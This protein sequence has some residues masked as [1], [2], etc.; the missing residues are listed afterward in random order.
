MS[1]ARAIYLHVK[2]P[3]QNET[4][5]D[6]F[7]SHLWYVFVSLTCGMFS[8]LSPV[9]C[10]LF[11]HL[12][13]VFFS[14]TCGMFSFLSPV[15]Y[16]RFSHLWDVF[17]SLT[18]GMFSFLSHVACFLFSRLAPGFFRGRVI[19]VAYTLALRW[20]P[21]RE[22]GVRGSVLGLVGPVSVYCDWVR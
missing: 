21:C 19:P 12:W 5:R 7:P 16:I 11:Y 13:H 20:L 14:L 3:R 4:N 15:G 17:F 6:F 1:D 18:C 10:F 9:V 2:Q 8:F 22:P